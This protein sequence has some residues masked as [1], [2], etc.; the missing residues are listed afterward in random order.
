MHDK[1]HDGMFITEGKMIHVTWEKDSDYGPTRYYDD[2]GDEITLNTGKTM[3]CVLTDDKP[4][5]VDGAV[6]NP[7]S[8]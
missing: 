3:V 1:T 4:F 7:S 5:E 8:Y 6:I 2:N